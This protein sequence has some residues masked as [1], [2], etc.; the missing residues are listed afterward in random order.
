MSEQG[1]LP[2]QAGVLHRDRSSSDLADLRNLMTFLIRTKGRTCLGTLRE[3]WK[4]VAEKAA[5]LGVRV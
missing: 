5:E 1:A 2:P 3:D 4:P